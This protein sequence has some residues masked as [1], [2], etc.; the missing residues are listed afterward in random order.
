MKVLIAVPLV[1]LALLGAGGMSS[2]VDDDFCGN[3]PITFPEGSGSS[4]EIK[5]VPPGV[6]CV[7]TAPNGREATTE[8]GS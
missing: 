4:S 7:Y 6:R 3:F 1:L 5:L 2:L 8:S